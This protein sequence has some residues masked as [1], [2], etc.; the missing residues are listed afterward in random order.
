MRSDTERN[1]RQLITAAARIFASSDEPVNMSEIARAA[2]VSPATAYRQFASVEEIL[3]TFRYEIGCQ[4]RDF[5]NK[6]TTHGITKLET[7]S[8]HWIS[9]VAEHGSAMA[10]RRSHRGYLDRLRA[11]TEYL[12][13]QA[14]AIREPLRETLDELGLTDIGDEAVFLWNVLF[15]PREILDLI[16]TVGL[17][18]KQVGTQLV[19]ALRGAL[20]GWTET[21]PRKARQRKRTSKE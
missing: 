10:S 7:V 2:E 13:P 11:G 20:I 4:L 8:R 21:R 16:N 15:D 19:A 6:Q 14:D 12:I 17:T 1:R 5:S 3:D 9:L 18:E